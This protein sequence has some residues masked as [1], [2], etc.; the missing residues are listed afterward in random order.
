MK[1]SR[2]DDD[3][4]DSAAEKP[5]HNPLAVEDGSKWITFLVVL[6][7]DIIEHSQMYCLKCDSMGADESDFLADVAL[8]VECGSFRKVQ[9]KIDK[10]MK[11]NKGIWEAVDAWGGD[12]FFNIDSQFIIFCPSED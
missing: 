6:P 3:E 4:G 12:R 10:A 2:D 9:G 5:R 8:L 1:R 7:D 11:E